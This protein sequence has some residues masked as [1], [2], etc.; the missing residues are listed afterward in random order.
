MAVL[1]A[2]ASRPGEVVT[3]TELLSAIWPGGTTYDEALTQ[4]VYQ[5]RQ[6]LISAGGNDCRSLITTVPKRG[7]LLKAEV[8]SIDPEPK[9][10]EVTAGTPHPRRG[11][12]IWPF[13]AVLILAAAGW[14]AFKLGSA[15]DTR[16]DVPQSQIIAVLPFLPL[17]EEE[18]DPALEF[19][20]ADTLITR[21]SEIGQLTVRPISSVRWFDKLD[22][23]ALEAGRQLGVDAVVDGSIQR[24]GE[25]I[26]VTVRLL[27]VADGAAL[28]TDTFNERFSGIFAVQDAISEHISTALA[29][30]L[31]QQEREVLT[32]AGTANT[33]AYRLYL[34]GRFHLARLTAADL[35]ASVGYFRQAVA[36][37]PGYAQAWLGLS[38][39]LFRST[40][41]GQVPPLEHYPQAR[42]ATEKALEIDPSL[43]EGHAMLG[44]IA[45]WFEWDWAASE[46]RF[47]RA[48]ELNPNDAESHL[49]YAHLLSSTGRHDRALTE[50]RRAREL[51][52]MNP[53]A[54]AL[55]GGFLSLAGQLELAL[56]ILEQAREQH[57]GFW[58]VR[59]ALAAAYARAG[60]NTEALAEV[61][62]ARAASGGSTWAAAN[63]VSI[64]VRLDQRA[65]AEALLAEMV[66]ESTRRYVPPYDLAMGFRGIGDL[67][68]A[69]AA[70]E[71][72]YEVRD[73][74]LTFLGVGGWQEHVGDRP[75]YLDL[76][77][78]MDLTRFFK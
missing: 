3:R 25:D 35:Q 55:E 44:R 42:L 7:Y 60:R 67:D 9:L 53:V 78:R 59:T 14:A 77:Q 26:R 47:I 29:L 19:G 37:D 38:D 24:A 51:S 27:R 63:E 22:R 49:G 72:A 56:Q 39:V 46:A 62:L 41:A 70:L 64:L 30:Q 11:L 61:R 1:Q 18:R 23:D 5:L 54:A 58:L 12:S 74:K 75:E 76:M 73:P 43:A 36:L 71:Q 45:F 15:T 21:L 17:V 13:A 69:L 50:I 57:G 31:G 66:L 52:P 65:E 68:A 4:C 48:I 16:S 8:S 34:Q 20:M 33:E 40:I 6:Q 32:R 10:I 2:L 28:W